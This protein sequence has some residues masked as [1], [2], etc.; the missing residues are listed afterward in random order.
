MGVCGAGKSLIGRG[1]A[2]A[3]NAVF[4]DADDYH[5]PENRARLAAGIPLSDEDRHPW[6]AV[7]R[8]RIVATRSAGQRHVMACSALHAQL[9]R[10]LRGEDAPESLLFIL[11]ESPR[12]V[13]E[14]R[15]AE[16]RGHFM[17]ASLLDSQFATLE[18][19]ADLHRVSNDR[20]PQSVIAE[21]LELL[22]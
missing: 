17:P 18:I 15:M 20:D 1:L 5:L 6:Y 8:Q 11:L 16:R 21:I 9:R 2:E 7:L 19:T 10:W 3:W 4:D 14:Q 13:I 22:T 12:A